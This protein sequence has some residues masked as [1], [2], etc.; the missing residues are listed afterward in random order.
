MILTDGRHLV[1]TV[2]PKELH[3]FAARIGLKREWYQDFGH[4]MPHYD[5]FGYSVL[6]RALA[7]GAVMV[8]SRELVRRTVRWSRMRTRGRRALNQFLLAPALRRRFLQ[9]ERRL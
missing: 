1:S 5:L 2:G 9:G 4:R 8:T 7:A 6:R 3:A